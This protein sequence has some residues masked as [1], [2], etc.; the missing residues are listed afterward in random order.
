M[1]YFTLVYLQR[2]CLNVDFIRINEWKSEGCFL[3]K[4]LIILFRSFTFLVV[5]YMEISAI[6]MAYMYAFWMSLN[7]FFKKKV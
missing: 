2:Y 1:R 4:M 6:C 5:L 3:K 7:S